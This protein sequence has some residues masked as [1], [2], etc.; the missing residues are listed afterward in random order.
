ML[1]YL[2]L[3]TLTICTLTFTSCSSEKERLANRIHQGEQRLFNDSTKS[4]DPL[5]AEKVLADYLDYASTYKADSLSPS[6]LFKAADLANGLQHAEQAISLYDKLMTEFPMYKKVPAALFMQGFIYETVI[7][8]KDKAKERYD[9][10]LKK[11]PEHPLAA[12][13]RASLD[14]LNSGLSDEELVKMFQAKQDSLSA[15]QAKK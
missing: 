10:F 14:Q 12:S 8:N 4:L 2:V 1:R 3:I 11:Y 13:A 5:E 6:F 9:A 15:N 7:H